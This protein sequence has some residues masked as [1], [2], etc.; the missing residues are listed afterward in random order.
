MGASIST[1]YKRLFVRNL[2]WVADEKG[3]T[4]CDSL[5][6]LAKARVESSQGG[7]VLIATSGNGHSSSWQIPRDMSPSEAAELVGEVIDRYDEA[8]AAL[9]G[10]PTDAQIITEMLAK[11]RPINNITNDFSGLRTGREE[12]ES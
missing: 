12:V 4:L 6:A 7:K 3:E 9:T 11:L 10:S 8:K 1:Q 2:L 5:K